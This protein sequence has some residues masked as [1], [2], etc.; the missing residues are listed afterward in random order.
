MKGD[1]RSTSLFKMDRRTGKQRE[2]VVV[3]RRPT[4]LRNASGLTGNR[5]PEY[6]LVPLVPYAPISHES[7]L[8][9]WNRCGTDERMGADFGSLTPNL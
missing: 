9:V 3:G 2:M 7:G 1:L 6:V 4:F 5:T 8:R